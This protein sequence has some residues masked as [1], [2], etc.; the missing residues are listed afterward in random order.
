MYLMVYPHRPMVQTKTIE[1][2]NYDKLPAGQNAIVAV[3]SFS[4]YDIEDALVL[5]K[6]SLDRG[7]GRCQVLRRH[8]TT[9]RRYPNGTY[10]RLNGPVLNEDGTVMKKDFE[11]IEADG[12]PGVGCYLNPDDIIIN[13]QTPSVVE[14][15]V[16][17]AASEV[18]WKACPMRHKGTEGIYVD[19]VMMSVNQDT[20]Q[21]FKVNTR[22]TRRPELGDKFSSR[23]GQ[24]GV[25]GII[26]EQEDLPFSDQGICPDIIMN[27]HGFPS[28][29]TV[30]KMIELLAGKAGVLN[31]EFQYGTCFGGSKVDDMSDILI[32]NGFSY[33][34][35]D[36]LTSGITGEPLQAYIFF[37]PVYYQKLK[38]MVMDKMHARARGPRVVMTRQ[39]TEGRSKDG[40][41]RLGEME[42]DCL[43]GYGAS[44]LL[45]ERL[46]L[47]SD[48]TDVYICEE[49]GL[50]GYA[51]WCTYCK[52]G[53][54]VSKLQI[55]Y[56]CKL[57]FQE[58]QAM[59][60][61]PRIQLSEY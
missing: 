2:I 8:V 54:K 57:L 1:L 13:K 11:N 59:N 10:D 19:K 29:M 7:F 44:Q 3:M 26:V 32:K 23:H 52:S 47:S 55:P 12:L 46:M 24:K 56:A 14:S 27:P 6:A 40:G 36:Y 37:G 42:R 41:L 53:A 43:I 30:G 58:L 15:T 50:L 18:T 25:C 39:P 21:L 35:K 51:G 16:P 4:G 48:V 28:R 34:G 60:V 17:G 5:N 38:H 9:I 31:G 20:Q 61:V 22:Q 33:C 45:L 49:C